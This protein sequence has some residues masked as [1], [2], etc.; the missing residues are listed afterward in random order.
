MKKPGFTLVEMLVVLAIIGMLMGIS[1]PFVSG[2]GKGLRIKTASKSITGVLNLAKSNAMT[3]RRNYYVAF[4][5]D[6]GRYWI[7]DYDGKIYDKKHSLPSS[8]K[9]QIQ[10]D[11][12][13]DP[14]TFE[15]DKVGFAPDGSV[16]NG[17]GSIT[18]TDKEGSAKTI[19]ILGSTG[20]IN[21]E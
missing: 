3:F 9:F 11:A 7:E 14:I 15:M 5:V 12:V 19:S 17:A 8:V 20:K 13:S 2:F 4:D 1:I 21:V 16:I 18:F 6:H 10:G